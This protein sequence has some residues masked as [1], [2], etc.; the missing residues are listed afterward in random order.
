[1]NPPHKHQSTLAIRSINRDVDSALD[2]FANITFDSE[3]DVD[4]VME[5]SKL[6]HHVNAG[7]YLTATVISSA[8]VERFYNVHSS[9]RHPVQICYRPVFV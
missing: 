1:M 4:K 6:R 2:Y 7:Q 8:L 5:F 9:Q 3:Y